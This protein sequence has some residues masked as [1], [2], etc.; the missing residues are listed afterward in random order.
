MD[1]LD[2]VGEYNVSTHSRPKAAAQSQTSK[3]RTCVFQH[4]AAR[5]RL[6]KDYKKIAEG[7]IVSTHSRPKAAAIKLKIL[8]VG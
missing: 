3:R 6:R 7:K 5:R 1:N 4:T 2:L 8:L